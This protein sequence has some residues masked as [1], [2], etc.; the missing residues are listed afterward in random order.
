[1]QWVFVAF[2]ALA[3]CS[4]WFSS[5]NFIVQQWNWSRTFWDFCKTDFCNFRD[6]SLA[7]C[8]ENCKNLSSK[9]PKMF[10]TV[11]LLNN[12]ISSWNRLSRELSKEGN[13]W[14]CWIFGVV[15]VP[16]LLDR[17]LPLCNWESK[18]KR[19][20]FSVFS[21]KMGRTELSCY[22]APYFRFVLFSSQLLSF[23]FRIW[24]CCEKKS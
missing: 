19:M 3:T 2:F 12:K 24:F 7:I 22:W 14:L 5:R 8:R 18:Q 15:I 17:D 1:M 10:E 4:V 11:S 23:L 6:K 20:R 9:K 21:S 16:S 13:R